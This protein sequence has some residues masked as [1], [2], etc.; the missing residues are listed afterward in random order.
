MKFVE[1]T[2]VLLLSM[3]TPSAKVLNFDNNS[4][5]LSYQRIPVCLTVV[6]FSASRNDIFF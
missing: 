2:I 5:I 3:A 4:Q 1:V 6:S